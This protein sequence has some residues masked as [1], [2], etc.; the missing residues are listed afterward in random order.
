MVFLLGT[1]LAMCAS[2]GMAFTLEYTNPSFRTPSEVLSE[3]NIPVLAA[4]PHK[5]HAYPGDGDGNGN[6]VHEPLFVSHDVT[7]D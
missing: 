1:L 4:V 2:I 6:G 7:V 3:L 5:F